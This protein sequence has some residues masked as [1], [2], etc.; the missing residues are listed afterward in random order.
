MTTLSPEIS[1]II[2]NWHI[3][4]ALR[5]KAASYPYSDKAHQAEA[6]N[7]AADTIELYEKDAFDEYLNCTPTKIDGIGENIASYIYEFVTNPHPGGGMCTIPQN[8]HIYRALMD[9]ANTYYHDGDGDY[10]DDKE[11]EIIDTYFPSDKLHYK[12]YK[13]VANEVANYKNNIYL[14]YAYTGYCG[15]L[16]DKEEVEEFIY[17]FLQGPHICLNPKNNDVYSCLMARATAF[18]FDMSIQASMYEMAGEFAASTS[19]DILEDYKYNPNWL[20]HLPVEIRTFI[21]QVFH[22]VAPLADDEITQGIKEV[23]NKRGVYYTPNLI[24]EYNTWLLDASEYVTGI[25]EHELEKFTPRTPKEITRW[26]AEYASPTLLRQHRDNQINNCII[27]YCKN[28][29]IKYTATMFKEC[30]D[31]INS[32]DNYKICLPRHCVN[33]WF[34]NTI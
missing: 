5:I 13:N 28:H 6:Y 33:K 29:G 7:N 25:W 17:K 18:T 30:V 34:S 24:T 3:A 1:R 16:T 10:D 22:R 12:L 26:F 14:D 31:W 19:I 15:N 8:E 2:N 4:N 27:R 21:Y 20:N 11:D 23:C 9:K 32:F